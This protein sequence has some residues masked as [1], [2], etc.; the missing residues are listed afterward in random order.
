MISQAGNEGNTHH[1]VGVHEETDPRVSLIRGLSTAWE[2]NREVAIRKGVGFKLGTLTL[3]VSTSD[4]T[5]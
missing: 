5:K 1:V 4:I 3:L 2:K